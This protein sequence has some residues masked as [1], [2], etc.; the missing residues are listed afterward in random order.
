MDLDEIRNCSLCGEPIQGYKFLI[1][2]NKCRRQSSQGPFR[3]V[4]TEKAE[5]LAGRFTPNLGKLNTDKHLSSIDKE[6]NIKPLPASRINPENSQEKQDNPDIP[7]NKSFHSH[8]ETVHNLIDISNNTVESPL[9][10]ENFDL[11]YYNQDN[12]IGKHDKQMRSKNP[13]MTLSQDFH[14]EG[15]QERDRMRKD[16]FKSVKSREIDKPP[17]IIASYDLNTNQDNSISSIN[18]LTRD[19]K[20]DESIETYLNREIIDP[21]VIKSDRLFLEL[22]KDAEDTIRLQEELNN[23]RQNKEKKTRKHSPKRLS[24]KALDA[25]Q[26]KQQNSHPE[27]K[28][29]KEPFDSHA[30]PQ[31]KENSMEKKIQELDKEQKA[32]LLREQTRIQHIEKGLKLDKRLTHEKWQIRKNS[33]QQVKE[34]LRLFSGKY[35]KE[36]SNEALEELNDLYCNLFPWIRLM[37]SDLNASALQQGMDT[38]RTYLELMP[39][40][41]ANSDKLKRSLFEALFEGL[42]KAVSIGKAQILNCLCDIIAFNISKE[43]NSCF[44]FVFVEFVKKL[45]SCNLKVLSF[46][47]TVL[48]E[49]GLLSYLNEAQLKHTVEEICKLIEEMTISRVSIDRKKTLS[50][51]LLHIL[52]SIKDTNPCIFASLNPLLNKQ[53]LNKLLAQR[54]LSAEASLKIFNEA[55]CNTKQGNTFEAIKSTMSKIPI[56]ENLN[57]EKIAERISKEL[58]ENLDLNLWEIFEEDFFKL[59]YMTKFNLRRNLLQRVNFTLAR[60]NSIRLPSSSVLKDVLSVLNYAIED[61][62]ILVYI[63]ALRI[64]KS[65]TSLLA[66]Y[67][68]EPES[69]SFSRDY[70]CKLK[71]VILSVFEKFKDKKTNVKQEIFSLFDVIVSSRVLGSPVTYMNFY[72]GHILNCRNQNIKRALLEYSRV[73]VYGNLEER[74]EDLFSSVRLLCLIIKNENLHDIKDLCTEV[75]IAI[76]EPL[77]SINR[78]AFEGLLDVVSASRRRMILESV[79]GEDCENALGEALEAD[80]LEER[81]NEEGFERDSR[82]DCKG[83]D[84]GFI[85]P[86]HDNRDI[87]AGRLDGSNLDDH[88]NEDIDE[89]QRSNIANHPLLVDSSETIAEQ[90]AVLNPSVVRTNK[91]KINSEEIDDLNKDIQSVKSIS[92]RIDTLEQKRIDSESVSNSLQKHPSKCNRSSR[93]SHR[94][95]ASISNSKLAEKMESQISYIQSLRQEELQA[96]SIKIT[97]SFLVFLKKVFIKKLNEDLNS[98]FIVIVNIFDEIVHRLKGDL[99]EEILGNVVWI[100]MLSPCFLN[101]Y[102]ILKDLLD[103]LCDL[104]TE[105]KL[106]EQVISFLRIFEDK[107][108]EF[109][110]FLD[111]FKIFR[112]YLFYIS[113]APGRSLPNGDIL[114]CVNCSKYISGEDRKELKRLIS[115]GSNEGFEGEGDRDFEIEKSRLSKG[116]RQEGNSEYE[117][118]EDRR[119]ELRDRLLENSLVENLKSEREERKDLPDDSVL[120]DSSQAV[121]PI[122]ENTHNQKENKPNAE[123][124]ETHNTD[125]TVDRPKGISD[126]LLNRYKQIRQE[127]IKKEKSE[128]KPKPKETESS[129]VEN[130]LQHIDFTEYAKRISSSMERLESNIKKIE[131]KIEGKDTTLEKG[132]QVYNSVEKPLSRLEDIYQESQISLINAEDQKPLGSKSLENLFSLKLIKIPSIILDESLKKIDVLIDLEQTFCNRLNQKAKQQYIQELDSVLNTHNLLSKCSFNCYMIIFEYTLNLLVNEI[133]ENKFNSLENKDLLV[134]IQE[135]MEQRV[136]YIRESTSS[137]FKCLI[138]LYRKHLPRNFLYAIPRDLLI[139]LQSIN[140]FMKNM[141]ERR[142]HIDSRLDSFSILKDLNDLFFLFPPSN[143]SS[144]VPNLKDLDKVYKLLKVLT[145][146]CV[147]QDAESS[148]R[149]LLQARREDNSRVFVDYIEKSLGLM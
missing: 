74:A 16:S 104:A 11:I 50:K 83:D 106:N 122:I 81:G 65:L 43:N 79:C 10:G 8:K 142:N 140:F 2:K 131:E 55:L 117:R 136:I 129:S 21:I 28:T 33:Y 58:P 23:T 46:M 48:L 35:Q 29:K 40:R 113:K 100:L 57:S 123:V 127:I 88:K 38:F 24:P 39:S 148:R 56:E 26:A 143:L 124:P 89:T 128:K 42:D 105:E 61:L 108:S 82:V 130:N 76:K 53:D 9:R 51:I 27:S 17:S 103:S 90:K 78:K 22:Q 49:K 15:N 134:R 138:F 30:D 146:C 63:E 12:L 147:S 94:E 98:H 13:E 110:D 54:T 86:A 45:Q 66:P 18:A 126:Q 137:I 107:N 68:Q 60:C 44:N 92:N 97:N 25:R 69:R 73:I 135:V 67:L 139:Y 3:R 115:A 70:E 31:S 47:Q 111:R 116:Y 37:I 77:V 109:L 41:L 71:V 20:Q 80:R 101:D 93:S 19:N 85:L 75:V 102:G 132:N 32:D 120:K 118:Q 96:F 91:S 125:Q 84:P 52:N 34:L 5:S 114:H 6:N 149:F 144:D 4:D 119:E 99:S 62:N 133:K 141:L 14:S 87:S 72:L 7:L 112:F 1:H 145:D 121:D 59:P 95:K 64:V 36:Q